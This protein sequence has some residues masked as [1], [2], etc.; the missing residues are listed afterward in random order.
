LV[1]SIMTGYGS[2]SGFGFKSFAVGGDEDGCHEAQGAEALGDDVGLDVSVVVY[3]P[4]ATTLLISC[5]RE[6]Y[7]SKP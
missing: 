6:V 7:S 1:L 2:M 5:V 3:C 4:S